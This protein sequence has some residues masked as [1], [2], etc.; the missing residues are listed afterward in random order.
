MSLPTIGGFLLLFALGGV[1]GYFIRQQLMS[2]RRNSI[3]SK[4]NKLL[5]DSKA[6][7]KEILLEA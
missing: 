4:V 5:E 3:E 1:V 7:A 2:V 6:E